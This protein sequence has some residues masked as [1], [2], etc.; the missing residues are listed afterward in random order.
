MYQ[1]HRQEPHPPE[2]F[3]ARG[4]PNWASII[5]FLAL[6]RYSSGVSILYVMVDSNNTQVLCAINRDR[7]VH[8]DSFNPIRQ[9]YWS[10]VVNNTHLTSMHIP[11][12]EHV[13]P[14]CYVVF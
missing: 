1:H 2:E 5:Y 3:R 12:E 9:I 4:Q 13:L 11:G 14:T 8:K 6:R 7:S 10:F